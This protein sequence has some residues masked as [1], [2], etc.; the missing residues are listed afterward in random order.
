M[1]F[2]TASQARYSAMWRFSPLICLGILF[3][4]SSLAFAAESVSVPPE[5]RSTVNNDYYAASYDPWVKMIL[6]SVEENHIATSTYE[7]GGGGVVRLIQIGKLDAA[8]SEL[9]YVLER[10]VNH[11]MA[12]HLLGQ[13]A[14]RANNPY[15][16]VEFYERAIRLYPGYAFTHVQ[17][18]KYLM[19][20]GNLNGGIAQFQ[21]A[22]VLDP[23]L[24]SAYA[25][26]A[27]AYAKS[28]KHEL[29]RQATDKAKELGYKDKPIKE[30]SED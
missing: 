10:I 4:I 11:P 27:Q 20:I 26:L 15:L 25:A 29:A 1:T 13:V 7:P 28:G 16:P 17:Y 12:L 24:P 6:K 23:Q 14:R 22:V 5:M 18:G 19:D 3:A 8:V 21:K 30:S 2:V 9:K